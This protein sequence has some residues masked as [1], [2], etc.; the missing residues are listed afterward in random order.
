MRV[1]SCSGWPFDDAGPEGQAYFCTKAEALAAAR[2]A[3]VPDARLPNGAEATVTMHEV[4]PMSIAT[5]V[6]LLNAAGWSPHSE[7]VAIVRNGRIVK[8]EAA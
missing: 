8:K 4:R 2:E 3:T 1:Y 7:V 6:A 5:V